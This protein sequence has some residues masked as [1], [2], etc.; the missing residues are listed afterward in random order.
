MAETSTGGFGSCTSAPLPERAEK[1][2]HSHAEW[3]AFA[4]RK[5]S[6]AARSSTRTAVATVSD[7]NTRSS[8]SD[9][10]VDIVESPR[11]LPVSDVHN[12]C[13]YGVF[14]YCNHRPPSLT[15]CPRLSFACTI[16]SDALYT[17]LCTSCAPYLRVYVCTCVCVYVLLLLLLYYIDNDDVSRVRT[18]RQCKVVDSYTDQYGLACAHPGH[19]H[20]KRKRTSERD[21][22][23]TI[24]ISPYNV[25]V[26]TSEHRVFSAYKRIVGGP[27]DH[28]RRGVFE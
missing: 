12:V 19:G 8:V 20:V 16:H 4:N 23:I 1:T 27:H 11:R 10:A 5:V 7:D 26:P 6:P 24:I 17:P 9:D 21:T 3:R 15:L 13:A 25:R 2:T 14:S 28:T 22:E 18:R